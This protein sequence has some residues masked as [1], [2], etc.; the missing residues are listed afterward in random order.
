MCALGVVFAFQASGFGKS[1]KVFQTGTPD[2][3]LHSFPRGPTPV[4]SSPRGLRLKLDGCFYKL[5]VLFVG[6]LK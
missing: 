5:G 4:S 6:V 2:Q 1:Y 3:S